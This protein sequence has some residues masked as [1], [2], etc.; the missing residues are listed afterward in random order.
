MQVILR[1]VDE[2]LRSYL[3][4]KYHLV[5]VKLMRND[6]NVRGSF[7]P[8]MPM[9]F[10]QMV[11]MTSTNGDSFLYG[12]DYERCPA[13]KVVLGFRGLKYIKIDYGVMPPE[14]NK[15]LIS[16]LNEISDVPEVVLA[17]LTP[18]QM[19]DLTVILQAGKDAPFSAE[20]K[21][22]HACAEFFAKPYMEGKP[23]MSLLCNGA[24]EIYSDFRD[25]EIIFG[26]PVEVYIQAAETIER[27]TKIGGAL[28][29]CRT[30]DIPFDIINEFE[31]I[32]FSKGTDYFF[33]KFNGHNIR[34]YLNKDLNG[35]MKFI[36]IHLPVRMPSEEIAE[37]VTE[38]L[39]PSLPRPYFINNRGYWLDFTVRASEGALGIDLFDGL[40]VKTAIEK[41][42]EKI[43]Q[44]LS[45][46]KRIDLDGED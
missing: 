15:V 46:A 3:G 13:A 2:V 32:G 22:E 43:T 42:I 18:K 40:T 11:R 24:R 31:K 37:R 30:S 19:M 39:S 34:L 8:K 41:F 21:G 27:I 25:D 16:P 44:Y 9:A 1:N 10:C 14:T 45:K 7:Q 23:D 28:C 5:G 38:Q 17:I 20:F 4:L 26:A 29:G 6:G 33:G 36:T 35:R 12:S